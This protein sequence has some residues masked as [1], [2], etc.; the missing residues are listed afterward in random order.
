MILCRLIPCVLLT[1]CVCSF[2]A[3][4]ALAPVDL[5]C[6]GMNDSSVVGATPRLWWRVESSDRNQAQS[7]WQILV[8]SSD[9]L[10]AAE[11]GDVWDSSK[12]S[13]GRSPIVRYA[14]RK[15]V[16][17]QRCHW[18]VRTWDAAGDVSEWSRPA[19]W[20]VAPLGP[21]DWQG[22]RWIDDGRENPTSEQEFYQP[23]PAPLMR[24]EFTL[25]KPV[26][27]ARL[28]VAGLGW[29]VPS[30]NGA[31]V[32][33]HVL[34]PPWTAFDKRILFS[35]HDVTSQLASGKNCLGLSLGNGWYNPLPLRMWGHRNIR[36]SLATGRPRAI[37]YLYVEH[38]DGTTTKV[39][40]GPDWTT[41]QGATTSNSVYL[42]EVR[43]ARLEL[44]GWIRA[45]FDATEWQSVRVTDAPLEPLCP[46][47]EMPPVRAGETFPAVAV[48][49]PQ[50]NV[51]I[52]DMG[53]NFTGVAEIKLLAPAGTRV[54]LRYGELLNKDG[55]LN[56]LTSVCGQIK[57]NRKDSEGREVS[58]GGPGAPTVA[59]QQDVYIARGD[60][61][62]VYRPEFTFH[63][64][65][66]LEVT[67]LPAAPD[68]TDVRG[69]ALHTDLPEA[70]TFSCSNERLNQIQA[71]CRQTFLSNVVSVQSDC[72]HR[73]RFAYGGDIVA[74]SESFLMNFDMAGFYAKTVRDWADGARP[75]GRFTDTAPFVG[76]DYCGVGW[77][78]VH[79]LLLEQL[80]Q[81]YGADSLLEE[82]VP[83]AIRWLDNEAA[84]REESLVVKGLSD[85]ETLAKAGGPV[86]TTPMFIN[87]AR[88]VARLAQ[89]IGRDHDAERCQAM[90][91]ESAAAWAAAF[92]DTD[93]GKVGD[94]SQSN[95]AFALGYGAAPAA[96]R[97][98][99]FQ[100]LLDG[101]KADDG[102]RLSTGIFGTQYLLE[103]LSRNGHS[104][105]AF[106][107]ADRKTFPSWGWMLENG[108][109]TLW[110]HWAGSDNTYSHNHPM[111]GSISG[112]FFRWLGGIQPA[113]DAVGFDRI[114]IRPQVV[115]GL[116]WVKCSHRS[117]RGLIESNWTA[118]PE[119]LQFDIVIP[120]GA[121][122][123]VELPAQKGDVLTEGGKPLD[124]TEGIEVLESD[125]ASFKLHVDSGRYQ[126]TISHER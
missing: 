74:T 34:A 50:P 64:F 80:H 119:E 115:A 10:L 103:E 30:L 35:T 91:D 94:G 42:G 18:K 47:L 110:E 67:G 38:P 109:T 82:Q 72:P 6:E 43:D 66:Y 76:I 116:E 96:A 27:R 46:L 114:E 79:P 99:V 8:A 69:I 73:E 11:K 63:G 1:F 120:P 44:P 118:S 16:A 29:C 54:L 25:K 97:P 95:Q 14:G 41:T 81:H 22:A 39:V 122:A 33:D 59:W 83:V 117:I 52:V 87:T 15:L 31:R 105:Q 101:L 112:W 23:D 123:V 89:L 48:T 60:G 113:R 37:A 90:A 55:T 20:E 53:Q 86:L 68:A 70:G 40:T 32:G 125:P 5:R 84:R 107:L 61:A 56:P 121:T 17:G 9:E 19:A 28:H 88:R 98:L 26:V 102:P 71:M 65:R 108:A 7:A 4:A 2:D 12:V 104:E 85:H 77:A 124:E 100:Q 126:F 111:F 75:D 49:T 36:Q 93:T 21:A 92:L 3:A 58:V 45:G 24:H 106:A 51:H 62:E 57:R 13:A 78:M